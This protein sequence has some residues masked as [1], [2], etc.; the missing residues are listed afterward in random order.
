M[1]TRLELLVSIAEE[2]AQHDERLVADLKKA[3]RESTA[4]LEEIAKSTE[5][6]AS[7]LIAKAKAW[8]DSRWW[9]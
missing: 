7:V 6:D 3:L 8:S 4:V 1:P 5:K 2:A 9:K